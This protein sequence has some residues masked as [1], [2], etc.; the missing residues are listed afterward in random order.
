[1][2]VIRGHLIATDADRGKTKLPHQILDS[3]GQV[4]LGWCFACGEYEAGLDKKCTRE[5]GMI[6]HEWCSSD[7]TINLVL[8]EDQVTAA[9][10]SGD[11]E[12]GARR[13]VQE[14]EDQLRDISTKQMRNMVVECGVSNASGMDRTDLKLYLVWLAAGD[15]QDDK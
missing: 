7:G 6:K 3:N 11:C 10:H 8:T 12:D 4:V 13:V 14:I 5:R 9:Y 2:Q 15:I 1:M